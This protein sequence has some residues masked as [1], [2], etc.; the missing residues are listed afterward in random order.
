MAGGIVAALG[1][2][3]SRRWRVAGSPL[4]PLGTWVK[5]S[6][7]VTGLRTGLP[8]MPSSSVVISEVRRLPRTRGVD[9]D[10][11]GVRRVGVFE[12]EELER[13]QDLVGGQHGIARDRR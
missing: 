12:V 11:A 9:D 1:G 7:R 10:A 13:G 3:P 8:A 2:A 4:P 6:F 5:R